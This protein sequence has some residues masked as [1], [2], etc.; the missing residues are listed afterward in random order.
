MGKH[1]FLLSLIVTGAAGC[2]L[3]AV[4]YWAVHA[5][6]QVRQSAVRAQLVHA[7]LARGMNS[8]E[9]ARVL[10][11]GQLAPG[12]DNVEGDESPEARI[13]SILTGNHY[14]SKDINKI[15][16]AARGPEGV[17]PAAVAIIKSLA[18]SWAATSNIVAVLEARHEDEAHARHA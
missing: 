6:R 14:E 7:M 12:Y 15:L 17:D 13:V 3:T 1:D 9:I 8:E 10:L 16:A 4:G 11:A 18:E 2:V 5:W